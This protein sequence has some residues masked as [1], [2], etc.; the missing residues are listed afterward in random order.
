M[1]AVRIHDFGGPEALRVET[2]EGPSAGPGQTLVRVRAA[3]VG[4]W[5]AWIRTGRSTKVSASD[6][7]L[8]L[9]SDIAGV[10]ERADPDD[11]T[12]EEGD[13]VFGVANASFSG[14]YTTHAIAEARRLVRIPCQLS[15]E[16]AASLPVIG[17]TAWEM[18]ALIEDVDPDRS[19]T[20]LG[21]AG[22]VGRLLVRLARIRGMRV[23]AFDMSGSLDP[24]DEGVTAIDRSGLTTAC[25]RSQVVFDTIGG[26]TLREAA[27]ALPREAI[28]VSS[29]EPLDVVSI[30]R[31][32]LFA[33]FFIV[34]VRARSLSA[35]AALAALRLLKPLVGTVLPLEDARLAHEM[36]DGIRPHG[37]GKI[38]LKV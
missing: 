21:A 37:R 27:V 16:E 33:H 13:P 11:S 15:F 9:G 34:D 14:G 25:A 38:V 18:L 28:V 31:D 10:V 12:F 23:F 20:V 26:A 17:V 36:I 4:P 7:P 24:P 5:D 32:D 29:V 8:I 22:N 6:L 30:G 35:I 19:V 1:K 3:G 2:L